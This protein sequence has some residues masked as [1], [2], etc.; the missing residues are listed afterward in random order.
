MGEFHGQVMLIISIDAIFMP[1]T[2]AV[3]VAE[4]IG[5]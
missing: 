4:E 3:R 1:I 2:G 5:G